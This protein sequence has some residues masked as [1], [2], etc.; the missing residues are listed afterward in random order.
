[1]QT[2]AILHHQESLYM[3][4]QDM[5]QLKCFVFNETTLSVFA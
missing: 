3:L 5:S 1:M 4:V 2:T